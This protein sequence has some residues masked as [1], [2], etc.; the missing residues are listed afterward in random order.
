MEAEE[1]IDRT[2]SNPTDQEE[3]E[4]VSPEVPEEQ[5]KMPFEPHMR[6]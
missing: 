2:E 1:P 3:Q 6:V 5:E 4:D